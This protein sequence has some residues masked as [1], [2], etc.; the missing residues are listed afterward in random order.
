MASGPRGSD[1]IALAGNVGLSMKD[2]EEVIAKPALLAQRPP[3]RIV[4]F[5]PTTGDATQLPR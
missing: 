2:E 4:P 1:L 3:R 5:P